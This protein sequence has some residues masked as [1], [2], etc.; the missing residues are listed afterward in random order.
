MCEFISLFQDKDEHLE[1]MD[2]MLVDLLNA[3]WNAFVKFRYL[4]QLLKQN[5]HYN[6]CCF[7][8]YHGHRIGWGH[9]VLL[10]LILEG[11]RK[12]V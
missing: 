7:T 9:Y 5:L 6:T 2:G 8:A 10:P 4:I 1:L 11:K 12:K 3:K